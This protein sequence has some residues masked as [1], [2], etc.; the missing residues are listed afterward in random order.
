ML[1]DFYVGAI[2]EEFEDRLSDELR[3]DQKISADCLGLDPRCGSCWVVADGIV[4][5]GGSRRTFDYYGGFEYIDSSYVTNLGRY[6]HYAMGDERVDGAL[7]CYEDY[8]D[9]V[10]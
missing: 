3:P 8:L 9:Q 2:I 7:E 1:E 6:T 10:A 4:V 5:D